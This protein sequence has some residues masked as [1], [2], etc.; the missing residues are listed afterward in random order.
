MHNIIPIVGMSI[1]N[2][3]FSEANIEEILKI[4]MEKYGRTVILIPDIPAIS[5]FVALGYPEN[6]ARKKVS[7][8]SNTIK[9]K[10]HRVISR[11]ELKE[12]KIWFVNWNEEIEPNEI[13]KNEYRKITDLYSTKN[14]FQKDIQNATEKV[15]LSNNREKPFDMDQA[16]N[17]GIEYILAEFA[18]IEFIRKYLNAD[19][20]DVVY[21]RNWNVY[22]N[23]MNGIYD[24]LP[25]NYLGFWI[26][27]DKVA[28]SLIF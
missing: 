3:Y 25:K 11:L 6:R 2:S 12:E 14:L 15:L 23:Y 13:Y 27:E 24:G 19:M 4:V 8:A 5:T 10:V 28:K 22:E 9:N 7:Q 16:V 17:I 26:P 18:F 21:H 20:I 1:G